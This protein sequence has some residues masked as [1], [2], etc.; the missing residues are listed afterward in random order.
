MLRLLLNYICIKV[1]N[2]LKRGTCRRTG[3][4]FS[5]KICVFH[6]GGGNKRTYRYVDFYRRCGLYGAICEQ[7]LDPNRSAHVGLILYDNG[8]FAYIILSD[9]VALGLKIFSGLS[10]LNKNAYIKGS[11]LLLS[12]MSLF[13]VIN[14]VEIFPFY[15]ASI[16][17]AAGTGAILISKEKDIVTLKLRSG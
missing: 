16:A 1:S 14:S 17:R 15:G 10:N 9:G 12:T 11:S 8:L 3:R 7:Q 2:K 13:T 6:R 4:N 5:G